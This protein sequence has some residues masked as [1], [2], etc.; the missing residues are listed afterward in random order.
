MFDL[1]ILAVKQNN[2]SEI[3][4]KNTNIYLQYNQ[5]YCD[6]W[7]F[8]TATDGVWYNL[9]TDQE[10]FGGTKI[11][12]YL[13]DECKLSLPWLEEEVLRYI[14]PFTIDEK[15]TDS[16]MAILNYLIDQSPVNTLYVIARYQSLERETIIGALTMNEFLTLMQNEML[17]AN[18]CYIIKKKV[19]HLVD[20]ID[21]TDLVQILGQSDD[22][23]VT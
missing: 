12:R 16:F 17:H 10:E 14:T 5:R 2:V 4:P 21:E 9:L 8:M 20:M 7:D 23:A 3:I 6:F 15:Y 19:E 11:C 22:T 13:G 1:V 18:V